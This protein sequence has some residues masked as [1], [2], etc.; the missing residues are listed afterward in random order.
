M[1]SNAPQLDQ[2]FDRT[3]RPGHPFCP[4]LSSLRRW[5]NA[6]VL[7]VLLAIIL[8]YAYLTNSNRVQ[9]MCQSY[10]SELVGGRVT[11]K[12][13]SLSIFEG[14]RLDGVSV[15][16]DGSGSADSHIFDAEAFLLKY[17]PESI[18]SG[19][20]EATEILAIQPHVW[21]CEDLDRT[22]G[23][24]WNYS[25]MVPAK[26]SGKGG[27]G[28]IGTLPVISLR[29]GIIDYSQMQHG[30]VTPV[31]SMALEGGLTPGDIPGS[32]VCRLQSRGEE[33]EAL[34][35]VISGSFILSSASIKNA[36]L[37]NFHF[38][39]DVIRVLPEQVRQ[40]CDAHDLSGRLDIL[41][42]NAT[43]GRNGAKPLFRFNARLEDVVLAI[44]PSEWMSRP[45]TQRLAVLHGALDLMHAA[46]LNAPLTG[47]KFRIHEDED[48][49]A[50]STSPRAGTAVASAANVDAPDPASD[51]PSPPGFTDWLRGLTEPS[52]IRLKKVSG[53]L[54]FSQDGI[55]VDDLR[56]R[57][58]QN[59]FTINGH[60]GGY[61]PSA[62]ADITVQGTEVYIP[63]TP[64]YINSLPRPVH[65]FWEHL[66]PEGAC[67]LKVHL[68]RATPDA[69]PV[70]DG[71]M[72]VLDG[73][74]MC[75]L[76]PYP[77]QK[78]TG[79]ITF[80]PDAVNGGERCDIL[81]LRG[82]STYEHGPNAGVPILIHGFVAPLTSD[83]ECKV[84]VEAHGVVLDAGLNAAFPT[85][86]RT[87]TR[88]FDFG[89]TRGFPE[90]HGGFT[91]VIYRPPGPWKPFTF[92]VDVDIDDASG[93]FE[94]FPYYIEHLQG[95]I[96]IGPGH[97]D[98]INAHARKGDQTLAVNG[99]VKFGDNQPLNPILSITARNLPVDRK[100]IDALPVEKREW[101]DKL[102]VTG[103]IDLDG[104]ITRVV[105]PRAT[106]L[107]APQAGAKSGSAAAG[108]VAGSSSGAAPD[109][110]ST[111]APASNPASNPAFAAVPI[112]LRFKMALRDGALTPP[113]T[114]FNLTG[115]TCLIELGGDKLI[116][117]D[118]K[119]RRGD[120]DLAGA[121]VVSWIDNRPNLSISGV[122]HNLPLDDALYKILP[123]DAR[124]AWDQV[125][126]EGTVDADLTYKGS[127]AA[128]NPDAPN[129]AP[130]PADFHLDL[131]ARKTAITFK[132]LP[133]KLSDLA[134]AVTVTPG[135]VILQNVTGRHGDAA[136][137][138]AGTGT[139]GGPATRSLW[140]VHLVGKDVPVNKEFKRALPS[141][142]AKLFDTM[143]AKGALTFD[144]SRIIYNGE[145][146][147]AA[148]A[149]APAA[150][151]ALP[152]QSAADLDV[153]GNVWMT[154]ASVN[155]GVPLTDLNGVLGIE[156]H[157]H[158]GKLGEFKAAVNVDSLNI[159]ERPAQRFVATLY[160][161]ADKDALKVDRLGCQLLGG[162]LAGQV[163]MAFPDVGN[164]RYALALALRN[165][166]VKE[167]AHLTENAVKGQLNAS[168][169]L[170]GEWAVPASRRGRGDVEVSGQE[171]YKIPLVLGLLQITNLSLPISSP[172]N[173]GTA[174][175][176]V[177][178]PQV[179][180]ENIDLRAS[181]MVMSGSGSL[182][183]ETRKV[184]MTFVT[185]NPAWTQLPF[186]GGLLQN[187]KNEFLQIH[188]TGTVQDPKVSAGMMNTFSTTVDQ[189]L[190]GSDKRS[191]AESGAGRR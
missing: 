170:E 55:G 31:G 122:A 33:S 85:D 94:L 109:S 155:V 151:S 25:R 8:V 188:V 77:L 71:V 75:D 91:A 166:D 126:P 179:T 88:M 96:V 51:R 174:R 152:A 145:G 35:P 150:A 181:N 73:H 19:K 175:Y 70:V 83:A 127:V 159:A 13:A 58:E 62:A 90:A 125:Q 102:G 116:L 87:A 172:F 29:H 139:L 60:I 7:L 86:A 15:Y 89:G 80:G 178:G 149:E 112:D 36:R 176:S 99:T 78:V 160:K 117:R 129:A 157:V 47:S 103:I 168:L 66:H 54:I 140:D 56:G 79:Q 34:G 26:R 81:N 100:L 1:R 132:P 108:A 98:I 173:Q 12:H 22:N 4:R 72:D 84:V 37:E 136:I 165:V 110:S 82:F 67:T 43:P 41:E 40:W 171:M 180:F 21:L 182:N 118:V 30:R 137:G 189:V 74:F 105:N 121:G 148:P 50:R 133:Y 45:E 5:T 113:D 24:Q 48:E 184:K 187:A 191:G 39:S 143:E 114:T 11:I 49:G 153:A 115:V 59:A 164:S 147:T 76:F 156:V 64:R 190:K 17:N 111:T 104:K 28:G 120:A 14:L 63:H 18:L 69:K 130:T 44:P 101:L 186:V 68:N 141:S 46:G 93:A 95:K 158:D 183:F 161:P 6:L 2:L 154:G 38:S 3:W 32:Y 134:G 128:A 177:D 61:S 163:D 27:G 53:H 92:S 138:I 131:R 107:P 123:T 9:L 124:A 185:D 119:A 65:E 97:V 42:L 146:R 16:V 23:H 52:P 162:E 57:I 20:L 167:L 142:M 10:L 135:K 169:S 106:T 144:L